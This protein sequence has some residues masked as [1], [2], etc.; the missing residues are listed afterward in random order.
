M[1]YSFVFK[2]FKRKKIEVKQLPA[3]QAK[4][5]VPLDGYA[6]SPINSDIFLDSF[7]E[8]HDKLD[9][10]H[11]KKKLEFL[12][13]TKLINS[14]FKKTWNVAYSKYKEDNNS[15]ILIHCSELGI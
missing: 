4:E 11:E 15:F 3:P 7:R 10:E 2:F 12:N 9:S 5:I 14:L 6:I 13:D 1:W 8:V